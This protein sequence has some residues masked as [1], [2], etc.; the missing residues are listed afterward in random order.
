MFLELTTLNGRTV[1]VNF[2]KVYSFTTTDDGTTF[3]VQ[4][5]HEDL[6]VR[7]SSEFILR[8][9]EQKRR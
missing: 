2:N 1:F 7:E 4:S 9:L 6:T 5:E 8:T 3:I